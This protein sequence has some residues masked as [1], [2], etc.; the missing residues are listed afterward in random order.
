MASQLLIVYGE[1]MALSGK[2]APRKLWIV[3]ILFLALLPIS[4]ASTGAH[5]EKKLLESA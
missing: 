4:C 3:F 5:D 2:T 1:I